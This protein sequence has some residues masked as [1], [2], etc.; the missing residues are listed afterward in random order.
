MADL[1][2]RNADETVPDIA[3]WGSGN[4]LETG[5]GVVKV[6]LD[7]KA[8]LS[9]INNDEEFYEG[10]ISF[11]PFWQ[12]SGGDFSSVTYLQQNGRAWR[13][14]DLVYIHIRIITDEITQGSASAR[15][16]IGGLPFAVDSSSFQPLSVSRYSSFD[17]TEIIAANTRGNEPTLTLRK[18][19]R[20]N[21]TD[22]IFTINDLDFE[23]TG[24]NRIQISG[25]YRR[26]T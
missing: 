16:D 6:D 15:A 3:T 8:S 10:D 7:D 22:D 26:L 18:L 1:T 24:K 2:N 25:F 14:G 17:T 4:V 20:T 23:G 11:T 9:A 21:N 19:N 5:E 12:P 13:I